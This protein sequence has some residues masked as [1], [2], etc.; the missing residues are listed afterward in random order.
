MTSVRPRV[1]GAV[2]ASA[3]I[4]LGACSSS[5]G[6]AKDSGVA[7]R[8]GA[9]GEPN[10]KIDKSD[11]PSGEKSFND[12]DKDFVE[13]MVPHHH[14]A[15]EMA[16]LAKKYAKDERVGEFAARIGDAQRGEIDAMQA[17]LEA[18]KL[19]KAPLKATGHHAMHM[20][21]MLT[22]ADFAKLGTLRGN[23]FDTFYVKK[24]IAHHE[25]AL[26][27]A[28][29]ALNEGTDAV[30]RT[31]AADVATTQTVEISRLKG[32]LKRL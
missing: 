26:A 6:E 16:A 5:D 8:A 30:N 17:W 12:A 23:A 29:A 3:V 14:Q 15:V 13:M 22:E 21:G 1:L 4:A 31:F 11:V 18:R 20:Q 2:I 24:M 9:P 28:D 7:V 32:I 10:Q 25:G 27:M 19:P